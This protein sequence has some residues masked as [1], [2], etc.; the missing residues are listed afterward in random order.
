MI[1]YNYY[2]MPQVLEMNKT[3]IMFVNINIYYVCKVMYNFI[4]NNKHD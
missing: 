2:H 1:K 3:F 4:F